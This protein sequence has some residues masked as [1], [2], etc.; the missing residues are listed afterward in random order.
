MTLNIGFTQTT[1]YHPLPESDAVWNLNFYNYCLANVTN[2][3][4]S[5][6]FSGDTLINGQIYQKMICSQIQ[7]ISSFC[8]LTTTSGYK[9]AI[10]ND[11]ASK[12]VFF[13]SPS[14]NSEQLLYD[15]NLQVGDTVSGY[16]GETISG[17]PEIVQSIDSVL[18]GN[19][20]RKRWNLNPLYE[21][22]F[23]EGIG[24]T[25]GL[26]ELLPGGT[27][28]D[29]PQRSINCFS[30]NG[31]SIYPSSPIYCNL[32]SSVNSNDPFIEMIKVF[33][34]PF[35]KQTT[36]QTDNYFKDTRLTL[37]NSFG[38][39]IK[40]I[41]HISG[42]SITLFRNDLPSGIYFLS[43]IQDKKVIKTEK[44]IIID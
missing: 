22:Y 35:S 15:F 21:V 33:P 32:I 34:N 36:L 16:F 27:I 6:S 18:I 26:I 25:Y 43:L 11:I 29:I 7:V 42:Q 41:D 24:S 20:F 19:S 2:E 37:Y 4:Y 5:L 12:K 9:G 31:T 40:Q 10:R 39:L 1:I 14:G 17:F 38:K 28:S 30:Q 44:L 8:G 23:I 3:N 13:V